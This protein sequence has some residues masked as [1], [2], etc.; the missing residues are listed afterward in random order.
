M[1][2]H[3]IVQVFVFITVIGLGVFFCFKTG[4]VQHY[5]AEENDEFLLYENND[6]GI[7]VRLPTNPVITD[8][9]MELLGTDSVKTM[10]VN[11]IGGDGAEYKIISKK[12][13]NVED[14]IDMYGIAK[15]VISNIMGVDSHNLNQLRD[16]M[17]QGCPAIYY[18]VMVNGQ[19]D[20]IECYLKRNSIICFSGKINH[21]LLQRKHFSRYYN[22]LKVRLTK[23]EEKS[24]L[25]ASEGKFIT[26]IATLV[27]EKEDYSNVKIIVLNEG[28]VGWILS[29]RNNFSCKGIKAALKNFTTNDLSRVLTFQFNCEFQNHYLFKFEKEGFV[30]KDVEISTIL[31]ESIDN[32]KFEPYEFTVTLTKEIFNKQSVCNKPVANIFYNSAIGDFDF[33][34]NK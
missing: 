1:N 25:I 33:I 9:K 4:L 8:A 21:P 20:I 19:V 32:P 15:N 2:K 29:N 3:T 28:K 5:L 26:V 22:S 6:I 24:K 17:L 11:S 30:E 10:T 7:A 18:C 16:T 34:K 23:E 13:Y 12:V 14:S 31:P 27:I